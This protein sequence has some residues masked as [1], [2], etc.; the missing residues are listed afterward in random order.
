MTGWKV[1]LYSP[2][3]VTIHPRPS[4]LLSE[5]PEW[6][7]VP[8]EG[9]SVCK[10]PW[11]SVASSN[12]RPFI[13]HGEVLHINASPAVS[14][15]MIMMSTGDYVGVLGWRCYRHLTISAAHKTRLESY[16]CAWWFKKKKKACWDKGV[17]RD[18]WFIHVF[19]WSLPNSAWTKA[20]SCSW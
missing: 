3:T 9:T 14:F 10:W 18:S 15:V 16:V 17:S 20:E 2:Q 19:Y 6:P 12:R 13:R 5:R 11:C 4:F 1:V 8:L 7:P